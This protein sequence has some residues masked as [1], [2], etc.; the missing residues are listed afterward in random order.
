M[1]GNK[2]RSIS[3]YV[4]RI[5]GILLCTSLLI[6]A[7]IVRALP[8]LEQ[9]ENESYLLGE[10]QLKDGDSSD[11]ETLLDEAQELF[12]QRKP[13]DARSKL[14]QA[15][16]KAP[17][18]FRPH[19]LLGGYYLG[20][21]GHFRMA[22]RYLRKAEE[23][24]EK[25]YGTDVTGS[26]DPMVWKHHARLLYLL[27]EA[28]LNLDRYQS[29]LDTLDRFGERYWDDWYPG[30][31]AWV[32]MKLKR[33]DEAIR[34]AQTGLLA[35]AEPG[36]TYNILGI[37]LSLKGNRPLALEAFGRA[38]KAELAMG[39]F[40]QPATPLNNSGEVYRELFADDYAEASWLQAIRMPDGCDHIL[41]SLNL[42][43]LYIDQLRLFQA[44]RVLD[45]FESCFA[46]HSVRSDT[47]HRALLALARGKIALRS[48]NPEKAVASLTHALE[49]EQ[50]FGKIGTNENDL[51][52]AATVTMGQALRSLA[53]VREQRIAGDLRTALLD[54]AAAP[55]LRLR[56]WWQEKRAREIALDELNDFEDLTVRN[57]DTM[58]EYP[59]LGS[60]LAGFPERSLAIRMERMNEE[61]SRKHAATY[62]EL[63]LATNELARGSS[64]TALVML[65]KLL[66]LPREV[67]RLLKA[68]ILAS[69]LTAYQREHEGWLGGIAPEAEAEWISR[70][71]ELYRL[72]PSHLRYHGFS[73]PVQLEG[74]S[75]ADIERVRSYLTAARFEPIAA[76]HD[77]AVPFIL[78]LSQAENATAIVLTDEVGRVLARAA[79][80]A[81]NRAEAAALVNR[82]IDSAF[83]HRID[84]PAAPVPKL[85][86]LDNVFGE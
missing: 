83:S 35:G 19:M 14:L 22:Y 43:I 84:P 11:L 12:I 61:D 7:D 8:T 48:G 32:L 10:P 37:L 66:P 70:R 78:R 34:V 1:V 74:S 53:A 15:L 26:A 71:V 27:A 69:Y 76:E 39:S 63:W 51:R 4:H 72:L 3:A 50:W 56:A 5:A 77:G 44:E 46:A 40:G 73:L 65:R 60:V 86:L 23:L 41:P 29:A 75:G 85:E 9:T 80:P 62:Y 59:T 36:R 67:D 58:I 17:N 31:R 54:R 28:R 64:S 38:L 25:Q 6:S 33:I 79:G 82:F 24:F 13:I 81:T 42:T 45:D 55:L 20:E 30:T 68:E 21:V 47:E 16:E 49:R 18:D 57:T 52:F 2:Q